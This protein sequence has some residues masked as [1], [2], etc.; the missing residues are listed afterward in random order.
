[1]K[2]GAL[3]EQL[4]TAVEDAPLCSAEETSTLRMQIERL[5]EEKGELAY[6]NDSLRREN[7]RLEELVG[8]LLGSIPS[9][10]DR[11]DDR[12]AACERRSS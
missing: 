6:Q 7:E 2:V 9:D 4:V 10:R 5:L 11:D 12:G 3:Q 8:Y 1:M